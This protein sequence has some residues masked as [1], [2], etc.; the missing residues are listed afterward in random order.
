MCRI[1][2]ILTNRKALTQSGGGVCSSVE[3]ETHG[4]TQECSRPVCRVHV[5]DIR[6][7]T[8]AF[9]FF[10]QRQKRN[11]RKI[12]SLSNFMLGYPIRNDLENR[13]H[14]Q[15]T[16]F[17]RGKHLTNIT[18]CFLESFLKVTSLFPCIQGL[19]SENNKQKACMPNAFHAW[20]ITH[21]HTR[22]PTRNPG[23]RPYLFCL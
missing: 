13:A 6:A 10:F 4:C 15:S 8:R 21:M 16:C 14:P 2:E 5:C 7:Q 12:Y 11:E 3:E 18:A 23:A 9:S 1:E 17:V 22:M 20:L 19:R